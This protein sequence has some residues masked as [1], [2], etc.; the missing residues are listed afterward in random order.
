VLRAFR[1][2]CV[3]HAAA[4]PCLRTLPRPAPDR[5][6]TVHED[7]SVVRDLVVLGHCPA[8]W[9][10]GG[11][12]ARVLGARMSAACMAL[13]LVRALD[14][15]A[16]GFVGADALDQVNTILST[17]VE[18]VKEVARGTG[19]APIV[20]FLLKGA[21][22]QL[23]E[24][25]VG[26][27]AALTVFDNVA[28]AILAT[29]YTFRP[30]SV[31]SGG[32][33][34][35]EDLV[36]DRRHWDSLVASPSNEVT[37]HKSIDGRAI[38][39]KEVLDA[40]IV[41]ACVA[42]GCVCEPGFVDLVRQSQA[43]TAPP[44]P[45]AI[46]GLDVY[47][48]PLAP[49]LASVVRSSLNAGVRASFVLDRRTVVGLE[50]RDD[51]PSFLLGG[52]G[53]QR[54]AIE[55]HMSLVVITRGLQIRPD[56]IG[57]R[58]DKFKPLIMHRLMTALKGMVLLS[59]AL[60]GPELQ[61]QLLAL[62]IEWPA[63]VDIVNEAMASTDG[64]VCLHDQHR[65]LAAKAHALV[66]IPGWRAAPLP[67]AIAKGVEG[68]LMMILGRRVADDDGVLVFDAARLEA[69]SADYPHL[70]MSSMSGG[71]GGVLPWTQGVPAP[72]RNFAV[73]ALCAS[74]VV[75]RAVQRDQAAAQAA[76]R[77]RVAQ[78]RGNRALA[79]WRNITSWPQAVQVRVRARRASSSR[80][81]YTEDPC[82]DGWWAD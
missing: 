42:T 7:D 14:R 13:Q 70:P 1:D 50:R 63:F 3:V 78:L 44:V 66:R 38:A 53:R 21:L 71:R 29:R 47:V 19:R 67:D 62:G 9:P 35:W 57:R 16:L 23:Q 58:L 34:A 4:A 32:G 79:T 2:A 69:G 80:L 60:S 75:P 37:F 25:R 33:A 59:Q 26:R 54:G 43:R 10:G 73:P 18:I 41:R 11:A 12:D 81:T 56:I 30:L 72:P 24:R 5:E 65:L 28:I 74:R 20:A 77:A 40:A 68:A 27:A 6:L 61:D 48:P 49:Y 64:H 39:T 17:D 45:P 15:G 51:G 82:E 36:A 76:A 31:F 8:A 22:Q 55:P 46:L 52:A